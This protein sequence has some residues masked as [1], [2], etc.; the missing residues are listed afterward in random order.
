MTAQE[1]AWAIEEERLES[2]VSRYD[3]CKKAGVTMPTIWK[4]LTGRGMHFYTIWALAE[5]A[6]LEIVVRKK[7]EGEK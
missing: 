2:G 7:K 3:L 6:G 1:I 5:A 4:A